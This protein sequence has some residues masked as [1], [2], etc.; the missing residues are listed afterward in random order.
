M[1]YCRAWRKENGKENERNI[2]IR[3]AASDRNWQMFRAKT[4]TVRPLI[5]RAEKPCTSAAYSY[6][7][8]F[9]YLSIL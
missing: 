3:Y 1:T 9:T 6:E 7:Y 4:D 5:P 8:V 2:V